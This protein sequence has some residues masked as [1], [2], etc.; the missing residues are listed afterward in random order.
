MLWKCG[1]IEV[2]SPAILPVHQPFLEWN[3]PH[4]FFTFPQ[5][6]MKFV[7]C[8]WFQLPASARCYHPP[9]GTAERLMKQPLPRH[10][11]TASLIKQADINLIHA[12]RASCKVQQLTQEL[13]GCPLCGSCNLWERGLM[14]SCR[15]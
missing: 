8:K 15:P 2:T 5:Q 3:M 11:F 7:G 1:F 10:S 13:F 14:E 9:A 4:I 12:N 6:L